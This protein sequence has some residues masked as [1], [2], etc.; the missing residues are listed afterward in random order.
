MS[1]YDGL[2]IPRSY[3]EYI[4]KTDAATLSQA[5]QLNNVL[6]QEVAAGNN[7]AVTSNAVN[8]ALT[9]YATKSDLENCSNILSSQISLGNATGTVYDFMEKLISLGVYKIG[10]VKEI[11]QVTLYDMSLMFTFN[12]FSE[13]I[14]TMDSYWRFSGFYDSTDPNNTSN[15]F[16]IEVIT[17]ERK[18]YYYKEDRPGYGGSHSWSKLS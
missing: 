2:I 3:S 6:A 16:S 12:D 9:N 7:K 15:C 13:L 11:S 10:T 8:G 18:H 1:R 4:N 17:G 5:L 14:S